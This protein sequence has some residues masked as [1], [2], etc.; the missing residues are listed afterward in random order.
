MTQSA[1]TPSGDFGSLSRMRTSWLLLLVASPLF[2]A[3]PCAVEKPI[4]LRGKY[5][6]RDAIR[7]KDARFDQATPLGAADSG[8]DV[9]LFDIEVDE[10]PQMKLGMKVSL[11]GRPG[12]FGFAKA[13]PE[14]ILLNGACGV[15]NGNVVYANRLEQKFPNGTAVTEVTSSVDEN[16]DL[17]LLRLQT[18]VLDGGSWTGRHQTHCLKTAVLAKP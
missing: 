7:L 2:A 10:R 14:D 1:L 13:Y 15:E 3:A 5:P 12:A 16:G 8:Y 17:A 6:I 11:P 9:E 4:D 18:P